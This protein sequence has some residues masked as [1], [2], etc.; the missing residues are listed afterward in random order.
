MLRTM[1]FALTWLIAITF[2][3]AVI[4]ALRVH[5]PIIFDIAYWLSLVAVAHIIIKRNNPYSIKWVIVVLVLPVVGLFIYLIFSRADIFGGRGREFRKSM[6][7]GMTFL[8]KDPEVYANLGQAFPA[9]KRIA[10]Y[11]GRKGQPLYSNTN[12]QYYPLGELQFEAMLRDLEAAERFIF[13]EY[14]IISKGELW[15]KIQDILVRKAAQGV[16]VRVMMDDIGS[17]MTF[18]DKLIKKLRTQE[19]QILRFNDVHGFFSGYY[20]NYRNHQKIAVIDGN[21]GYTGGTNLADEYI[22]AFPKHGHWKD[23]AIRMEGDA[24]WS[25]TVA[26]LQMWDGETKGQSDYEKYRPAVS[27]AAASGFFQPFTDQPMDDD[28]IAKYIYKLF[29][30]TAKKYIYITTPYLIVDPTMLEA[31]RVAAKG[32]TDVRIIVP[33]IWDKWLVH[34][35]TLSNY[36]TLLEAGVRIYEYTPGFIHCKTI[37]SDDEHAVIGT[38]NMDFRS[39]YLHYENGVWICDAPVLDEI[40]KDITDTFALCEEIDLETWLRRPWRQKCIQSLM[41]LFAVLF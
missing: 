8:D 38:I 10:G 30:Y 19:I 21:I 28:Y 4:I 15:D 32:G 18:P 3:A 24:V 14:F 12:C 35:V 29:F 33:K 25:L 9:R 37:I 23:N 1:L 13:M 26:F 39:F 5:I 31:L 34:V 41:R 11:L 7:R 20:F 2:W 16:E 22:N 40:K 6:A 27:A 17:I 36:Q